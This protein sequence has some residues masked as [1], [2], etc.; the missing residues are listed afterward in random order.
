M[1]ALVSRRLLGWLEKLP[2]WTS[3]TAV[4]VGLAVLVGWAADVP[5]LKSVVPGL[6]SMKA[7]TA[8]AFIL[9]G[10]SVML[11][12]SDGGRATIATRSRIALGCTV[13]VLVVAGLT[14]LEYASGWNLGIDQMLFQEPAGTVGTASPGRM[15]IS[16]AV[17]FCLI[18]IALLVDW[19]NV[20][21]R[22][23]VSQ[24]LAIFAILIGLLN[25]VLYSYGVVAPLGIFNSTQMAV[26]TAVVFIVLGVGVLFLH[27]R[28]AFMA[29]ATSESLG[30]VMARRLIPTATALLIVTGWLRLA[31]QRTGLYP[32]EVG[33]AIIVFVSVV[34]FAVAILWN[35]GSLNRADLE[36]RTAE[37]ALRNSEQTLKAI[38]D[39]TSALIYVKDLEGRYMLVNR[40]FEKAFGTTQDR[41]RGKT[42][43]DIFPQEIADAFREN[44]RVVLESRAPLEVEEIAPHEDGPHVY[45]SNKFPLA[46]PDGYPVTVCGVSTDIT[47]RKRVEAERAYH[48]H[49]LDNVADAV[50]ATDAGL[51]VTSWNKAAERIYGWRAEEALG[52]PVT[53]VI[54]TR[55][56]DQERE[57]LRRILMETGRLESEHISLRKDGRPIRVQVRTST[58]RASDGSVTGTVSMSRDVTEVRG[59]ERDRNL[60][61]NFSLDMLCIAGFDGYFKQLNP[62]WQ[63]TLEWTNEELMSKPYLD[64]VHPEDR[65]PTIDAAG[66][67]ADGKT[68]ITFENRYL[69][70]DGSY[71]W[72]SWNSYPLVEEELIFA[73]AR[74]VTQRKRMEEQLARQAKELARSNAELEQ[75]A[76]I[77][78]HD[79]Q[80]PLRMVAS[81]TQ[82]LARRYE[83]RLDADADEFI[84]YAVDGAVQMQQMINDLL[85]FSR[86]GTKGREFALTDTQVILDR[87]LRNLQAAIQDSG[88]T[89]T[90]NDMPTVMAD[91]SQ[92][93]QVFQ[94][95]ISNAIKF[96]TEAPPRIQVSAERTGDEWVFSVRDNGIGIGPEH[97]D[98]LFVMFRRLH[99]N[100]RYP[101][102]GIGLAI[103]RRIV[104]RH[105][106]RIWFD[107]EPG[108]GSTFHFTIPAGSKTFHFTIPA[109]GGRQP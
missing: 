85:T 55:L 12:H 73:V 38:I 67:L 97:R 64:F 106:G 93:L 87:A 86:V 84:H 7:N 31:G 78:S 20:R 81:Y 54:R 60:L 4:L 33:A 90:H 35:A 34:A 99:N 103:C 49:V 98:R 29:T 41:V 23:W 9:L 79:L 32:A 105:G 63:K 48:A 8:L 71:R 22:L 61:F 13:V 76:Y 5:W 25:V 46:G 57:Q 16:T 59:A 68:V 92:L 17:S 39:N 83:G 47:E 101:G 10:A 28:E 51:A 18:G 94:N 65:Q 102:T 74:D 2:E 19:S 50:I 70:K 45:V 53:A 24:S 107:S 75:F 104:E 62:A 15:A 58:I 11:L 56:S 40:R 14:L 36:R 89:I 3:A 43:H 72:I 91:D 44:D 96:R 82:L 109:K 42:D 21:G 77:A 69:C 66:G 95:L 6:V 80:E 26:H 100:D 27:P 88:A 37:A 108:K 1:A 30:G 52:R